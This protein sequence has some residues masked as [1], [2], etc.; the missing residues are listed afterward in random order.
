MHFIIF[1]FFSFFVLTRK[2]A[3]FSNVFSS[4]RIRSEAFGKSESRMC[5]GRSLETPCFMFRFLDLSGKVNKSIV[6]LR[7][8]LQSGEMEWVN[9]VMEPLRQSQ[10]SRSPPTYTLLL[11]ATTME[12]R[13]RKLTSKLSLMRKDCHM[14]NCLYWQVQG[15]SNGPLYEKW[16]GTNAH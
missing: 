2:S 16:P 14:P 9:F 6:L 8:T 15:G 4:D 11:C 1:F 3:A 12:A 7:V 5:Y 13:K 10:T